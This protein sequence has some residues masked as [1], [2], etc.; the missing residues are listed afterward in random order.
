MTNRNLLVVVVVVAAAAAAVIIRND[1]RPAAPQP[2]FALETAETRGAFDAAVTSRPV[3][4]IAVL[5]SL[6]ASSSFVIDAAEPA[7]AENDVEVVAVRAIFSGFGTTANGYR[8]SSG[9]PAI[10]CA[11][12]PVSRFGNTYPVDGLRI[13]EGDDVLFVVYGSASQPGDYTI[14]GMRIT[15]TSGTEHGR[16]GS[17]GQT[18]EIHLVRPGVPIQE[19]ACRPELESLWAQP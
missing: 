19:A 14:R 3:I 17:T 15:Y 1:P 18:L 12:G 2:P 7:K 6:H 11:L 8:R 16:A 9:S 5:G 4:G 13:A 10:A